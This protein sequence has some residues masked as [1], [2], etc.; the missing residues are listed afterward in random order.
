MKRTKKRRRE[1]K[2][3]VKREQEDGGTENTK[4]FTVLG[5][6]PDPISL[7]VIV[8]F[9]AFGRFV[10]GTTTICYMAARVIIAQ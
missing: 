4:V 1:N 10:S 8:F 6:S 9:P 3:M 5:F 7:E 2:K